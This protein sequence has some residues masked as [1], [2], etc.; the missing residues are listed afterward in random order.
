MTAGDLGLLTDLY[1]LTMAQTYFQ[2]RMFAPATFSLFIR[3]Y[4]ANRSYFVSAGLEDVLKYLE[5][6]RFPRESIDYLRSTGIF[7]PDFLDYLSGLRFT[8]DVR[9]IPEGRLFFTGEPALEV[10]GPIIEAQMVETYIINQINLQ[11]LIATKAA[12]YVW[13]ARGRPLMDFSLRRTHGIDAGMKVARA[14]Y[15]AGFDSTSNVLAGKVYGIPMSGTMAHSFITSYEHELDAFRAFVKSF[16]D[17]SIL[18][19]D[20]YDTV[21]GAGRAATVG[22]EMEAAGQRLLGVRLDSGDFASLSREVRSV[23]D[24]EGLHYVSIVASGGL[25]DSDV[26]ALTRCGAPI[27]S[28]GVGTKMGIS[29][30]AP[31]SDMAYK[32]VRYDGRPVLKLSTGKISLPGEKQVFRLRDGAGRFSRDV[33]ALKD[34][35]LRPGEPL[36]RKVMGGGRTIGRLPSLEEIR[37]RFKGDFGC[38]EHEFKALQD[39]ATYEVV[40]S[41]RLKELHHRTGRELAAREDLA[42]PGGGRPGLRKSKWEER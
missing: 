3:K 25:D 2:N 6:W 38:L 21:T 4:P 41:A 11:S 35:D 42:G 8:G 34:E 15:V 14:S 33:L 19:I 28:F 16:P 20:T 32:L 17:R 22:R 12:R 10:T 13:A 9:A 40:L 29:A 23:L 31:W 39:P 5:G 1:E 24:R 7:S 37:G 30:D 27:D 26:E 18:L 36:L